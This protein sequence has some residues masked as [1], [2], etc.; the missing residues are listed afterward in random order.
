M[1]TTPSRLPNQTAPT[2]THPRLVTNSMAPWLACRVICSARLDWRNGRRPG[3][4][5]LRMVPG[6]ELTTIEADR[7]GVDETM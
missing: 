4:L 2:Y 6:V 3:V 1:A 5:G 7:I